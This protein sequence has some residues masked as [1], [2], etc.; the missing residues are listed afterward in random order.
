MYPTRSTPRSILIACL[1]ASAGAAGCADESYGGAELA[2]PGRPVEVV[3]ARDSTAWLGM[4]VDL[5]V[6]GATLVIADVFRHTVH[7]IDRETGAWRALGGEG[8]GPG[9]FQMPAAVSFVGDE[10]CR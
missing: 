2:V 7:L 1:V 10:L 6:R 4:P 3:S 5:D 8:T 9:E